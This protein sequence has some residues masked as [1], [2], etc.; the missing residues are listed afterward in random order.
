MAVIIDN[1]IQHISSQSGE[2]K[3][4]SEN[5]EN[6]ATKYKKTWLWFTLALMGAL[7]LSSC[8]DKSVDQKVLD[9]IEDKQEQVD[10]LSQD[11]V[12]LIK[13]LKEV[14]IEKAQ[15]EEELKKAKKLKR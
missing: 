7:S 2:I 1:E 5:F 3:N 11:E 15:A 8:W 9:I 6:K 10:D 13:E 14:R 12:K 4:V